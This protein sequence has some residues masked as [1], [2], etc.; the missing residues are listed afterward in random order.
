MTGTYK[1]LVQNGIS[2]S[3]MDAISLNLRHTK[4]QRS[5]KVYQTVYQGRLTIADRLVEFMFR[6]SRDTSTKNGFHN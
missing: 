1:A 3:Y 5:G 2:G 4:S 6:I